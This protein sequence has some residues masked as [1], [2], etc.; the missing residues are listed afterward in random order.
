MLNIAAGIDTP[1]IVCNN[2]AGNMKIAGISIPENSMEFYDQ[3]LVW[4]REKLD[5]Q[6]PTFEIHIHLEY[7]N[8]SSLKSLLN[9]FKA[10]IEKCGQQ[11]K[12][13]I[14][15]YYDADDEDMKFRGEE[16]SMILKY[17]FAYHINQ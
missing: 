2:E 3:L 14:K 16:L 5:N 12:A 11:S 8:T 9:V 13:V 10:I 7:F 1:S 15:W 4:V 6:L 17:P